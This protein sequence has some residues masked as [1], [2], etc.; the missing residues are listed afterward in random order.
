MDQFENQVFRLGVELGFTLAEIES[1]INTLNSYQIQEILE[2][3]GLPMLGILIVITQSD[4]PVWFSVEITFGD[5]NCF[6]A[7]LKNQII[8][9][10]VVRP[11]LL[12]D[13][14]RT[15]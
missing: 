7:A 11:F 9:N 3:Y 10:L 1:V 15:A 6:L 12:K 13:E 2:R 4:L 5:G 8:E 14:H